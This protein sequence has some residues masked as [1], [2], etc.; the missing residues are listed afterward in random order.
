MGAAAG[1]GAVRLKRARELARETIRVEAESKNN[2]ADLIN[3][4]LEKLVEAGWSCR[5]S[6]PW[7]TWHLQRDRALMFELTDKLELTATSEDSRVLDSLA[8]SK[9]HRTSRDYIPALDDQ[10]SPVD[11]SHYRGRVMFE[12]RLEVHRV[13]LGLPKLRPAAK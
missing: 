4:A 1:R 8:H 13:G 10:G 3:V 7:T 9:R 2:P 5:R 11:T 12:D 6:P